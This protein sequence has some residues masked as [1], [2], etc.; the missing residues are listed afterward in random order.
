MKVVFYRKQN[1]KEP[2]KDEL[3]KLP[4]DE[5]ANAFER[6]SGIQH[7]GFDFTRVIFKP[8]KGKLWEI[9]YKYKNQH[10]FLY[11][12]VN[13]DMMVLLHYIK[14]K[15]QKLELQDRELAESRMMEV[16]K[17]GE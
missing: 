4:S 2:V 12:M 6:L 13:A 9:K 8:V 5:R 1:G 11:C 17:N 3:L 14:K 10:R 7:Y 16:I 15:T